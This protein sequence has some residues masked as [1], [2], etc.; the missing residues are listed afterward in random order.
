MR[1][2]EEAPSDFQDYTLVAVIAVA[3]Y[4]GQH[5]LGERHGLPGMAQRYGQDAAALEQVFEY[6]IASVNNYRETYMRMQALQASGALDDDGGAME[7]S[8]RD[9]SGRGHPTGGL[10]AAM[11]DLDGFAAKLNAILQA[12]LTAAAMAAGPLDL[13]PINLLGALGAMAGDVATPA[14]ATEMEALSKNLRGLQEQVA[15][16]DR[17]QN[18]RVKNIQEEY[19]RFMERVRAKAQSAIDQ[20]NTGY[21]QQR[22]VLMSRFD[23]LVTFVTQQH[24]VATAAAQRAAA[25]AAVGGPKDGALAGVNP[26]MNMHML[27]Q[28]M[29]SQIL[30]MQANMAA[31]A[32]AAAGAKQGGAPAA[33]AQHH[34]AVAAA[35]AAAHQAHQAQQQQQFNLAQIFNMPEADLK[36]QIDHMEAVLRSGGGQGMEGHLAMLQAAMAHQAA[37]AAATAQQQQRTNAPAANG[38]PAASAQ[39]VSHAYE[40]VVR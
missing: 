14:A 20:A 4:L 7:R 30:A 16:L 28:S 21:S 26:A 23:A 38:P 17:V 1:P 15:L 37:T 11:S 19:Q 22:N 9:R 27:S 32:A 13:P 34:A 40:L 2:S 29:A 12:D 39:P 36:Q 25:A 18:I 5:P 33:M 10:M 24:Q 31:V 3:A 6:I 35:A 8:P